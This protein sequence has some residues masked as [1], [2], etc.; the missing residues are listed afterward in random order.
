MGSSGINAVHGDHKVNHSQDIIPEGIKT[1]KQPRYQPPT[2]NFPTPQPQTHNFDPQT[3]HKQKCLSSTANP[4]AFGIGISICIL[5]Y[6]RADFVM[7]E[8]KEWGIGGCTLRHGSEWHGH[9]RVLN[10]RSAT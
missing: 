2:S 7:E 3:K 9:G 8:G 10:T 4:S 1:K 5:A 6:A